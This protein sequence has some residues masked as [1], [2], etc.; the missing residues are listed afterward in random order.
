MFR[1]MFLAVPLTALLVAYPTNAA[2]E[3]NPVVKLIKS[4]VKDE[5]KT[6]AILVT[7]K[8]KPG[9]EKKFEEAF[10]PALTA[11]RKEPGCVA[12]Y[13]N[14]DPEEPS[15]Y[16]MYESFKGIPGLEA[17]MKEKHTQTLLATVLPMCEGEP[18]IKVL[19]VPE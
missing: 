2:D 10:G 6:F 7:F 13:L 16:I 14:H 15:T 5:K 12:Y 4:K 1:A 17:H 3:E 8:V 19:T 9:N 11:T 18:K